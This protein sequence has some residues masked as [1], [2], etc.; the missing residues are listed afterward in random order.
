MRFAWAARRWWGDLIPGS[1]LPF[2]CDPIA[3]VAPPE[4]AKERSIAGLLE[5]ARAARQM[6]R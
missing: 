4:L 5:P 2:S 3:E 6:R 1:T